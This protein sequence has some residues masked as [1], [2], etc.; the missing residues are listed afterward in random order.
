MTRTVCP[1]YTES[2]LVEH[3]KQ[4]ITDGKCLVCKE[5]LFG[6]WTDYNGQIRCFHC[7]TTYQILG[8]HLRE[9]F[10]K[11]HG[12]TKEQIAEK[13]CDC[14]TVVPLL[15]D[16]WAETKDRIPFGTFISDRNNP[17]KEEYKAF[18]SWMKMNAER[19]EAAY[20]DEFRWD[21][22]KADDNL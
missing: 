2:Q 11:K 3:L 8:C 12:L 4:G 18:W 1:P 6:N 19:Y 10:L 17:S 14:Y 5:Q 13:Y 22:I 21:S 7:G 20:K 9:E 16:Y 15:C